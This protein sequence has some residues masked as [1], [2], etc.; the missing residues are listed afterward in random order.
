MSEKCKACGQR[1]PESMQPVRLWYMR[2]NHTFRELPLAREPAIEI[3]RAELSRPDGMGRCGMLCSHQVDVTLH[4]D[5]RAPDD[6]FLNA[7]RSKIDEAIALARRR[8]P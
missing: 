3:L 7:A 1:L 4:H 6:I 5:S 8:T 2:D